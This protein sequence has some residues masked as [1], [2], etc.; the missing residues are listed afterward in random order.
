MTAKPVNQRVDELRAR[1][2]ALGLAR[3][4]L[5]VHPDDHPP[6]KGLADKLRKKREKLEKQK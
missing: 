1:R 2:K 3:L 5:Y 4:E 6:V